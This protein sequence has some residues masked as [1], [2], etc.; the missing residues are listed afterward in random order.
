MPKQNPDIKGNPWLLTWDDE[1]ARWIVPSASGPLRY[2]VDL[3]A[4]EAG[5]WENACRVVDGGPCPGHGR[6]WHISVSELR[7][8]LDDCLA[9]CLRHYAGWSRREL[10][11]ED[12]R[13]RVI[14][15]VEGAGPFLLTQY[16][17]V[18]DT[19]AAVIAAAA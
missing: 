5:D 14:M 7:E 2:A 13:L 4:A 3:N 1:A 18:G 10:E 16:T 19:L 15:S 9:K 11:D 6:C 8:Q 12:L 17:A